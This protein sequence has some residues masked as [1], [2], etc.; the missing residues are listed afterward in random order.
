[1]VT[2]YT[3]RRAKQY[4]AGYIREMAERFHAESGEPRAFAATRVLECAR[5]SVNDGLAFLAVS[6]DLIFGYSMGLIGPAIYVERLDGADFGIYVD[7]EWRR[8]EP[9]AGVA[10]LKSLEVAI[11]AA[12]ADRFVVGAESGMRTRALGR[13]YQRQGYVEGHGTWYRDLQAPDRGPTVP[14]TP[15]GNSG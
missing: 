5:L 3:I 10:L 14:P 12:G 9:T 13:L 1:L 4:E 6:G 15:G 2:G 7:P 8:K 11:F